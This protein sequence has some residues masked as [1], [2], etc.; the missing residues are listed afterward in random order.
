MD[1]II[2]NGNLVFAGEIIRAD[3]AVKNGKICAIGTDIE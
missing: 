1:M 3:I 2:K